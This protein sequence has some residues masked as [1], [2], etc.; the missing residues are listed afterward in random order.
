MVC[1][2]RILYRAHVHHH[3]AVVATHLH[4]TSRDHCLCHNSRDHYQTNRAELSQ[5]LRP[6]QPTTAEMVKLEEVLDEE[7]NKEQPM[8]G[9]EDWDTDDG[10][11]LLC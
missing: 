10:M 4:T 8:E 2:F 7:F 11:F 9:E 1:S 6:P 3:S 5:T